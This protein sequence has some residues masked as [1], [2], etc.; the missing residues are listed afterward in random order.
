MKRAPQQTNARKTVVARMQL[1]ASLA[2]ACTCAAHFAART[3]LDGYV[4]EF[5]V[6][7][8]IVFIYAWIFAAVSI[9][10]QTSPLGQFSV[11]FPVFAFWST[12]ALSLAL[13]LSGVQSAAW[14]LHGSSDNLHFMELILFAMRCAC[15]V[16]CL[17][18]AAVHAYTTSRSPKGYS[19]LS[20]DAHSTNNLPETAPE[21]TPILP[22]K[23]SVAPASAAPPRT[24]SIAQREGTVWHSLGT[25]IRLLWPFL[26]PSGQWGLQS[27]IWACLGL[28]GAGRVVNLYVPLWYKMVVD[29]LTASP[30]SYSV[31]FPAATILVY[32]LL[33]FLQGGGT[34]STG[35]INNLRSQLWIRV[36]QF[37]SR[38][39]NVRIFT[40]LHDLSLRWHL[41]RKTGEVLRIMD[42]GSGSVG[43]L[44]DSVLF[45]IL[46][47]LVDIAVAVV[48]FTTSFGAYF[49]LMVFTTMAGYIWATIFI[50]EW[51]T[52]FRRGMNAKDNFARQLAVDSL[53]N[54]ETV[55][56]Y[57]GET[58]EGGRFQAAIA[59]YQ[60]QE[61]RSNTSLNLLSGVQNLI[62]TA[63]LLGGTLLAGYLVAQSRLSVGDFVLYIAYVIQ[64]YAPLNWFGTYYYMI[65]QN[66]VDMEN[67][68]DLFEIVPEVKDQP[69]ALDLRISPDVGCEVE[70]SH[71]S[72]SYEPSRPI[73]HDVSFTVRRG[74]T[75][76]IVGPTGS[77]KSTILRL[78]FRF[79][80]LSDGVIRIN[81][82][83]IASV[84]QRSLRS[85][86]GVVPQDTV[87]FHD[88]I[89]YNIQYGRLEATEEEVIA[90]ASQAE[91][92][93][94][95]MAFPEK[96]NTVV[97]ERGLK[98][99]G[100]EKQRVAIARTLLKNPSIVLL[101]E[102]TS[103]L[104]TATERH[105]QRSLDSVCAGRTAIVIA[106]RLSTITTADQIIVLKE[107]RVAERGS[108][109][110][111]L[112]A[113]GVYAEMWASQATTH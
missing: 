79:Y 113:G 73:L 110:D 91:M 8:D 101:D 10:K 76:A 78:L 90:A 48:Y 99:S 38:S 68:L 95:I 58:F 43:T 60:Q 25:N 86:M 45:S 112:A 50:T 34:G 40:H 2:S 44:L 27:R 80:D 32:V 37:T 6:V 82:T 104:D 53:L 89:L 69:G 96:Y 51:R 107:G 59:D 26:W 84:T 14:M 92:H 29:Q 62:I 24:G 11:S 102:A 97:G 7:S 22:D 39:I 105:I 66:F 57:G 55:K 49:G 42:R 4:T 41:G 46:P 36:S 100:G 56:Y 28:L 12:C 77:G 88:S 20:M 15:V 70:F 9:H 111:L 108:H 3:A 33:R 1:A 23:S 93:K 65:Q 35:F 85:H 5:I 81:G 30:P 61:W 67:M 18:C 71:V 109:S 31:S 103:A 54:F 16:L 83:S 52:G 74:Q 94:S 87:L 75:L 98:L 64:L 63:G 19:P 47:T 17:G 106:H 21:S 13:E 72:F